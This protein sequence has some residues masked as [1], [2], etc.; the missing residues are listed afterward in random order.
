MARAGNY[1]ETQGAAAWRT[2]DG[3]IHVVTAMRRDKGWQQLC[4]VH[5]LDVGK[6]LP[7]DRSDH[8]VTCVRCIAQL[9]YL[10]AL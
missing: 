10:A 6:T 8:L 4:R 7:G 2:T 5:G 3:L 9:I 1:D